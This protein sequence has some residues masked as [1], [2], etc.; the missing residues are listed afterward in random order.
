MTS[1]DICIGHG[2]LVLCVVRI[3][4]YDDNVLMVFFFFSVLGMKSR[5]S[6][7]LGKHSTIE[8][9]LTSKAN[10][11]T[12]SSDFSGY[13]DRDHP[14]E[15]ISPRWLP[16]PP[17]P[18][19]GRYIKQNHCVR[20]LELQQQEEICFQATGLNFKRKDGHPWK[21]QDGDDIIGVTV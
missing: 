3:T 18:K 11:A 21:Y 7:M 14:T 6:H 2:S 20:G 17:R 5:A 15:K 10:I 4:G 9:H 8:L 1:A 13:S 19:D 12:L 16:T